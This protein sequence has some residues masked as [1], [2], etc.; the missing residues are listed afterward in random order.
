MRH[1]TIAGALIVALTVFACSHNA[2]PPM[3]PDAPE[4][5]VQEDDGGTPPPPQGPAPTPTAPK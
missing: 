1:F 3:V 2:P 4:P 5:I